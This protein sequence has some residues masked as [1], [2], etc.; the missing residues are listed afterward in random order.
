LRRIVLLTVLLCLCAL[1]VGAVSYFVSFSGNDGANGLAPGSAWRSPDNGDIKGVLAPGDSV[2]IMPGVYIPDRSYAFTTPGTADDPIVYMKIGTGVVAIRTLSGFGAAVRVQADNI[3]VHCLDVSCDVLAT[4]SGIEVDGDSCLVTECSVHGV[5]H[6]GIEVNGDANMILRNVLWSCGDNGL[7]S[8]ESAGGNLFYGNTIYDNDLSGMEILSAWSQNR[9]FNNIIVQNGQ[10]GITGAAGNV[11]GFNDVW[12]NPSGDYGGEAADS[13]GGISA[14]PMFV[15]GPGADFNLQDGSPAINA[16]LDLGYAY[17]DVAPDVGAYEFFG[18]SPLGTAVWR[19]GSLSVP[20]YNEWDGTSFGTAGNTADVGTWRII[21]G[22]EAPARDEIIVVG[23]DGDGDITG[24]MWNGISWAALPFNPLAQVSESF[25]WGFD[26]A[27][28][29]RS[30]RALLVWN[31]GDGGAAGLSSRLWDG[32]DWSVEVPIT[33]AVPGEPKQVRL[34]AIPGSNEIVLVASNDN[35]E[36]YALV[37]DGSDWG[38]GQMLDAAGGDDRTDIYVTCEQ[39]SGDALVTYGKASGSVYFRTWDGSGWS[40]ED[41]LGRPA[42]ASG[43]VRWTTLAPD[44]QSDR[45]VLG[46][47]TANRDIWLSVWD[48]AAWEAAETA[49]NSATGTTHPGVAVAFEGQSGEAL[50]V[51]G[52][53]AAVRFRTWTGGGGWSPEQTQRISGTPSNSIMLDGSWDTDHIMLAVQ[54]DDNDLD[55]T[56]WHGD[57]WG[58]SSIQA[59]DTGEDKNQ[60]FAFLWGVEH[61]GADL[62]VGKGVSTGSPGETDTVRFTVTLTNLGPEDATGIDVIDLLPAGLIYSSDQRSQGTYAPGSG[63]WSIGDLSNG[64]SATLEITA[65]VDMGT[66]GQTITN[67]A[68]INALDKVDP[69]S[70]ND[71]ARV[72]IIVKEPQ[73]RTATGVYMG[74]GAA[75]RT[76]SDIGFAPDVVLVKGDIAQPTVAKTSTM[77]G[78]LSKE[79]GPK[80]PSSP[81]LIESLDANGFTVG[82]SPQVNSAGTDYYWI[83]FQAAPNCMAVGCYVGDGQD[84]RSISGPGFMPGYVIVMNEDSEHAMQR[85]STQ[86]LDKSKEFSN[87]DE[88]GD[89]IQDF[90]ALG[91]QVGKDHTVNESGSMY[92]YVA[93]K[94]L[95]G[96]VADSSYVGDGA[97]NRDITAV[98]FE[99][100]Y[101]IVASQASKDPV[102]RYTGNLR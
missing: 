84:D 7:Q 37:W 43:N 5:Y 16:G 20:E 74:D 95:P 94:A 3:E 19:V 101:L 102:Q 27:Y 93:W 17:H 34:A 76:I 9:V 53:A 82:S 39:Q 48:G 44:P 73:F 77:S 33:T 30:G 8:T 71:T 28:E 91:F 12:N 72:S 64:G 31:N 36:D 66:N 80:E 22:A 6:D 65:T 11:C 23:V 60:P 50:A 58:V 26:V 90:E 2:L 67:T 40:S 100:E 13:S 63:L 96:L 86:D 52:E 88:K 24:E 69:Y 32:S 98:G 42:D 85:F 29:D 49:T 15:D 57:M 46:V 55:Y 92:H 79:L 62:V 21:A 59:T 70:T 99:P 1:P 75:S 68:V 87:T 41:S 38:N 56:L 10:Y 83:A 35:S 25:W 51:Y 18:A 54:D 4:I 47:L 61:T 89:R 97:D 45:I 81:D 14:D 78:D